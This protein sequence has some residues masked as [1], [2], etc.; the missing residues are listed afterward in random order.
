MGSRDGT[1]WAGLAVPCA[2]L[3][4]LLPGLP[5]QRALE[6]GE[7]AWLLLG[8]SLV[9]LVLTAALGLGLWRQQVLGQCRGQQPPGTE[10]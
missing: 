7:M 5:L 2:Q 3:G 10:G 8:S 1:A 6:Y 4:C 9:L